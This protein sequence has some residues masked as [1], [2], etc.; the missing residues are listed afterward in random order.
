MG[1]LLKKS[2]VYIMISVLF[3]VTAYQEESR[4]IHGLH[5]VAFLPLFWLFLGLGFAF[6][7]ILK[8]IREKRSGY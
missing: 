1:I 5:H 2:A 6:L 7:G 4:F 3:L 8:R